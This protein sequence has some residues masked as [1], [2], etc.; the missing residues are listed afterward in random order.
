[1]VLPQEDEVQPLS[2]SK[3]R[4]G[5]WTICIATIGQMSIERLIVAAI[6]WI[7]VV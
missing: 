7:G 4:H 2:I 3:G 6:R 1:M 5:L